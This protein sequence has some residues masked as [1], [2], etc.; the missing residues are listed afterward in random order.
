M[1][2][3]SVMY[4]VSNDITLARLLIIVAGYKTTFP[5]FHKRHQS[6][7]I[8]GEFVS[9]SRLYQHVFSCRSSLLSWRLGRL[10]P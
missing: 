4:A 5:A 3:D 1:S 6:D 8:G 10:Y 7:S 2:R 9:F